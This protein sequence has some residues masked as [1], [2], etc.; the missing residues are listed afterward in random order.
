MFISWLGEVV[1]MVIKSVKKL[2]YIIDILFGGY[3]INDYISKKIKKIVIYFDSL[4]LLK[5]EQNDSLS[6]GCLRYN[7]EFLSN[8]SKLFSYSVD[9]VYIISLPTL[10]IHGFNQALCKQL[11]YTYLEASNLTVYD[12]MPSILTYE[13]WRQLEYL[14]KAANSLT[15]EGYHMDSDNNLIPIE[16]NISNMN[17]CHCEE[18]YEKCYIVVARDIREGRLNEKALWLNANM[19]YLTQIPNS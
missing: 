17:E 4:S 10:T 15:Y 18:C 11:N 1:R 16:F 7:R 2:K 13:D 9:S 3:S 8:L 19:D 6:S 14:I 12:V 5:C